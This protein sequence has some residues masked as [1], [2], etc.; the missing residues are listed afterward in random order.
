MEFY[1]YAKLNFFC[2]DNYTRY[3]FAQRFILIFL[4]KWEYWS[5]R[6][7]VC[8]RKRETERGRETQGDS[9]R[10]RDRDKQRHR[11]T[12]TYRDSESIEI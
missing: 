11:E 12:E 2:I 1:K 7:C 5:M 9:D 3:N 4:H 6:V 8:G 10:N